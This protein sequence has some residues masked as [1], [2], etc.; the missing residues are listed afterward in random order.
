[1]LG[2][3]RIAK[4]DPL[5]GLVVSTV[6]VLEPFPRI[7]ESERTLEEDAVGEE[8]V[9]VE[10]FG[11]SSVIGSESSKPSDSSC[12]KNESLA[13]DVDDPEG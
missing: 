12:D 2:E 7:A 9:E 5:R 10:G 3:R 1:M 8:E 6:T 13:E 11:S 4:R